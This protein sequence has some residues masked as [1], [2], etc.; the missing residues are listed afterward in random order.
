MSR[1]FV[2]FMP[3]LN[4][5]VALFLSGCS[6]EPASQTSPDSQMAQ[7]HVQIGGERQT[8]SRTL[9]RALTSGIPTEVSEIVIEVLNSK[10]QRLDSAD[11]LLTGK[12]T[13]TIPAGKNY[14]VNGRAIAGSELLYLGSTSLAAINAGSQVSV[15]LSLEEQVILSLP[16]FDDQNVGSAST[17]VI[18]SIE[19]LNNVDITWFVNNIEGGNAEVGTVDTNGHYTPPIALPSNPTI[20]LTAVPTVAPS[21]AQSVSFTLLPPA[22]LPPVAVA[23]NNQTVAANATV[24]L[25][26]SGSSDADDGIASYQWL[27]IGGDFSPTLLNANSPLASFVAPAVQYG[28]STT[29]QL[30]VVDNSGDSHSDNV[31]VTVT[32]T[33]QP[34]S[35]DTG[36]DQVVDEGTLV[37]LDGSASTDPDNSITQYLWEELSGSGVIL[38]NANASQA[39]FTAPDITISTILQ[40]RLTVTNDHGDE[41]QAVV[42]VTVN[43]VVAIIDKIFFAASADFSSHSLWV[44][45]GSEMNTQQVSTVNVSNFNFPNFISHNDFLYFEGFEASTGSELWRSDG[46]TI[47]TQLI[48]TADETAY[49]A[50]SAGAS[51]HPM[52]L[53][54]LGNHILYGANTSHD[55]TFYY[56]ELVS[57]DTGNLSIS[58]V[59]PNSRPTTGN[60]AINHTGVMAG[61][62]YFNHVVY[63]PSVSS[64]L[65]RTDGVN[66]AQLIKSRAVA[67]TH[68][69]DFVEMN[70]QLYFSWG[71]NELW[72]TDG[73]EV[74]TVLIKTFSGHVGHSSSYD[75]QRNM[76]ALGN[77]LIFVADDGEGREL[78]RSDGTTVGTVLVKDLDNTVASTNPT[79]FTLMNNAL[80]FIS[81]AGNTSTDGLWKTDG[82]ALGTIRLAAVSTAFDGFYMG[83]ESA[84]PI[85][86]SALNQLF[87]AADNGSTGMELW[88]SDGTI[89]GTV[90]VLDIRTGGDSS[91]AMF[92]AGSQFLLFIAEDDDGRSKLWRSDGTPGGTTLIKDINPGGFSS[93]AFFPPPA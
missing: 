90:Q 28:G 75:G 85:V 3:I 32:G 26:G 86:I 35:A 36:V 74:G 56:P 20:T 13:L 24:S 5:V 41:A 84:Q 51:A 25:D 52:S 17:E 30:S 16:S 79:E 47:G 15:S 82:T 77:Q 53:T 45:D 69:H 23:G 2:L 12:V 76:V 92:R 67:Y 70:G 73:T 14:T 42:N 19:G 63:T 54:R 31:I 48:P 60:G 93:V 80:F 44:T 57:L 78:W 27:H 50:L 64:N 29:L 71:F 58:S 7:I 22:N 87:F 33:D 61:Y 11:L 59:F 8:S 66:P 91:P 18:H 72:K 62:T 9:T 68:M 83:R 10:G 1:P 39:S 38:S 46:T 40:F 21:F 81:A 43:N 49:G 4:L 89:A 65:Y 88:T 6:N 55:G 37:T 34:L